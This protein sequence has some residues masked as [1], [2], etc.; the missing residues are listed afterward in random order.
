MLSVKQLILA[1]KQ[2]PEEAQCHAYEGENTGIVVSLGNQTGFI[3]C[4]EE[5][6]ID[7]SVEL[8]DCDN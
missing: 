2:F 6:D 8:L 4:S 5:L 7:A 3:A 1:L